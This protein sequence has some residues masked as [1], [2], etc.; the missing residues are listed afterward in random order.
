[1]NKS[2]AIVEF[3]SLLHNFAPLVCVVLGNNI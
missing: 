1:M 2:G 3:L